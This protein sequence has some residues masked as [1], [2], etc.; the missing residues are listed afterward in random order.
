MI[1]L[2]RNSEIKSCTLPFLAL[3]PDCSAIFL[4]NGLGDVKPQPRA[5]C[6]L[7]DSVTRPEKLHENISGLIF[8][9]ANAIVGDGNHQMIAFSYYIYFNLAFVYCIFYRVF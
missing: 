5:I 4:D 8:W 6:F 2:Q 1:S 9:Y 7:L 3:K